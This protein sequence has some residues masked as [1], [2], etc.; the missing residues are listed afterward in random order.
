MSTETVEKIQAFQP[1]VEHLAYSSHKHVP[2]IRERTALQ[3]QS[4]EK[5]ISWF[6]EPENFDTLE[7]QI[8]PIKLGNTQTVIRL[9]HTLPKQDRFISLQKWEGAVLEVKEDSFFARLVDLTDSNIDEEAE[10]SIEELSPEDRPLIKPGAIF[11]WNIGYL[12]KRSGQR[13]H[14][15][16]IRFRRLPAWTSKEIQQVQEEAARLQELFDWKEN[17]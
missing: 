3:K 1:N 14:A 4:T 8:A 11:Y 12:D 7:S 9:N 15:S 16:L 5:R 6:Y 10:F 2:F 13:I 17:E